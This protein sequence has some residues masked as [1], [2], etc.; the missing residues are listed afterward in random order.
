MAQS[1]FGYRDYKRAEKSYERLLKRDKDNLYDYLRIEYAIILMH[2]ERYNEA[3][4][5]AEYILANSTDEADKAEAAVIKNSVL[6]MGDFADNLEA[7]VGFAVGDVNS[8]FEEYS[9][10][11]YVDG[12]LYFASFNR[13]DMIKLDGKE[14]GY[15]CKIYTS[16]KN[17]DGEYEKPQPLGDHINRP[18]FHAANV[19][20]SADGEMMYFTRS[21]FENAQASSTKIWRSKRTDTGW[22][23]AEECPT[24]NGE[25][26]ATHP[27]EGELF[28]RK[29]LFFAADIPGGYG[30]MD[31]YYATI[32]GDDFAT[33]VN[34]GERINTALTEKTPFY[35]DGTLYFSSD[36]YPGLGGLDIQYSVWDGTVWSDV[37]NMGYQ[38]NSSVDDMYYRTNASGSKAFLVSNRPSK[39]KRKLKSETCCTDIYE[40]AIRDIIIDLLT[41][42]NDD[43]G[44]LMGA[45][46]EL[47]DNSVD[48]GITSKTNATN[49]DFNF[50]LESDHDYTV[51]ISKDG[52][53]PDTVTFNTVGVI[54][55]YTVKKTV[56]LK[57][58][59]PEVTEEETEIVEINQPIKLNNIYYDFE[60]WDILPDA[61]DDLDYLIEI[62]EDYPELVIE[63]S[64]HTDSRGRDEY[65]KTLSQ[66]RAESAKYYLVSNGIDPKRVVPVGY[67][68][69]KIINQC[70]NKVRCT[71]EEHRVNRRTEFKI[72][73]GPKTITIKKQV[74]KG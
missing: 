5:Q 69:E 32:Q 64:S 53:Y 74:P 56:T 70:K 25:W 12:T 48:Q 28:G 68:E 71:D 52:Y 65:N 55:D 72:I 67:G 54:D 18:G 9:P 30:G 17:K 20:F 24:I 27:V 62:M 37:Q 40:V 8:A 4:K 3:Y 35:K 46:V 11:E 23:A 47:I 31:I 14:E 43:A 29:V 51:I 16:K 6:K 13:R 19:S 44:P 15:E 45:T 60:K 22:S 41:L 7:S 2:N 61:E 66:K 33:P 50:L 34:L 63:L 39:D 57:A 26:F 59:P 38:Y 10:V 49:N 73:K 1:Q 42:V 58:A 36:G 21:K